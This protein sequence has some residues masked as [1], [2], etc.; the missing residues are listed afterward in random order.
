M[1]TPGLW[2]VAAVREPVPTYNPR[3]RCP[4]CGFRWVHTRWIRIPS[5][6]TSHNDDG[7]VREY[8]ARTC[9]RCRYWWPEKPLDNDTLERTAW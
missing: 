9:R 5:D 4:K 8:L 3:R 6:V 2:Q 1:L 7:L